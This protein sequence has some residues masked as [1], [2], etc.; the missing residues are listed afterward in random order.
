MKARVVDNQIVEILKPVPGHRIEE[1]FHS[2]IL[3]QCV[4]GDDSML[5]W[6]RQEDGSFQPVV[7]P[8]PKSNTA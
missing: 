2:D 7:E 5:G 1:C 3:N 4:D 6:I 8:E